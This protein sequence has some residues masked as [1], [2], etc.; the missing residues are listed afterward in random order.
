M[1]KFNLL[2]LVLVA[3]CFLAANAQYHRIYY[4]APKA[5]H[6]AYLGTTHASPI[7]LTIANN[8]DWDIEMASF[9]YKNIET[10][11]I[12]SMQ[13][14]TLYAHTTERFVIYR[15]AYPAHLYIGFA[16]SN[17]ETAYKTQMVG[18]W[19]YVEFEH[20]ANTCHNV[21][22]QAQQKSDVT[23]VPNL[24]YETSPSNY[25]YY[26][27]NTSQQNAPVVASYTAVPVQKISVPF[28][29]NCSGNDSIANPQID[30]T[31][32]NNLPTNRFQ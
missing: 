26:V 7:N 20:S 24:V 32:G 18:Q 29:I 4:P 10:K 16:V 15:T 5:R 3:N 30:L 25:P 17:R 28:S 11:N 21:Q 31:I 23:Y 14:R 8:S 13:D 6:T 12:R 1:R 27:H 22:A 9:D 19:E 2:L